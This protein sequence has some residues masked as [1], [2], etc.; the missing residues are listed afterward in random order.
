MKKLF[1]LIAIAILVT[2]IASA[3]T[4]KYAR[5]HTGFTKI[6]NYTAADIHFYQAYTY[7]V[8][9]VGYKEDVSRITTEVKGD[10][11]I[12]RSKNHFR[13]NRPF[14]GKPVVEICS[15]KFSRYDGMAD[16]H[17]YA[18]TPLK[19]DHPIFNC[20]GKGG[21]TLTD[22]ICSTLSLLTN[23][24]N[25]KVGNARVSGSHN[26]ESK[27]RGKITFNGSNKDM[28]I[29]NNGLGHINGKIQSQQMTITNNG[30]GYVNI[31][32]N[33]NKTNN[34]NVVNNGNGNIKG[35]VNTNVFKGANNGTGIIQMKGNANKVTTSGAGKT[36]FKNSN[37]NTQTNNNQHFKIK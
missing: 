18:E 11:L 12:I 13:S 36:E 6:E 37:K 25:I 17:F 26:I 9:I 5:K 34:V 21:I 35:K 27:G 1:S 28:F 2:G 15:P 32:G 31:K 33:G 29:N 23:T 24:A 14:R 10:V 8:N 19:Y 3:K 30:S 22:I 4:Y 7:A 20:M 16:G